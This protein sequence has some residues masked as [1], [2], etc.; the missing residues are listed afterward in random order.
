MTSPL[1]QP[2]QIGSLELP[3]RVIKSATHETRCNSDGSVSDELIEFYEPMAKA[4]TPLIITGNMW[5]SRQ[6]RSANGM[7]SIAYDTNIEGLTRLADNIHEHGSRMCV[8]L[9][10]CGRQTAGRKDAVSASDVREP[11]LGTK[12]RPLRRDEMPGLAKSFADAAWRA[13]EAGM[14]AV[15][16]HCAHGYL[17]SQFLTP[18]T[19]RRADEYGGSVENRMRIVLEVLRAVRARVGDGYPVIAKLNGDDVLPGRAGASLDDQLHVARAM[20][21]E[22]LDAI[23]IS[24]SHYESPGGAML[25][26]HFNGFLRTMMLEG[27]GSELPAWR[28]LA[29][30]AASPILE[31]GLNRAVPVSE[32]FNLPHAEKFTAVLEIPVICVGGFHTRTAMEDAIWH[33]RCDAVSVARAMIAD[34]YLYQHLQH[35]NPDAPVCEYVNGCIARA[36]GQPL[37]CYNKRVR[38]RR[39]AMLASGA[40]AAEDVRA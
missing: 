25:P 27:G 31:Q 7:A 17:L 13:A 18:H 12:P 30:L 26:G 19:N 14:D 28:R 37:N 32:G 6:G 9:N 3:G 16:I 34:A 20:Q 8:Q 15:Q 22:G 11:F 39:D 29:V 38:A 2:L 24:R 40:R 1:F 10:H 23:E 33:Q 21:E 35:E 36:G 5:I 4:G